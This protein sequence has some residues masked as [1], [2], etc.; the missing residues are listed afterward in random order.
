MGYLVDEQIQPHSLRANTSIKHTD[1]RAR[2][3]LP[4]LMA[5]Q[6]TASTENVAVQG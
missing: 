1:E 4:A 5:I 6:G 2:H 3:H